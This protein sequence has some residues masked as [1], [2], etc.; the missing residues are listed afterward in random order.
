M[1]IEGKMVENPEGDYV[2]IDDT[3]EAFQNE[4]GEWGAKTFPEATFRS[5]ICHLKEEVVELQKFLLDDELKEETA[6]CFLILLHIAH[7]AK[8]SILEEAKKKMEINYKRTWG[9]PD[10]DGVVRHIKEKV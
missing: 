5:I 4:V 8:F 6:D 3:I 10:K 7:R 1:G 9:K 2:R